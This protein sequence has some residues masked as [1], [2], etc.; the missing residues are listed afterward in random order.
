MADLFTFTIKAPQDHR[1]DALRTVRAGLIARGV[2]QPNVTPG[3]DYYVLFEAVGNELSVCEA[4]GAIKADSQLPDTA[5]DE[6]LGR[7]AAIYGLAKRAAA[8]SVGVVVLDS[9]ASSTITTGTELVDASGFRYEVT[10]GGLYADGAYVPIAAI[11]TGKATNLAVGE[12]LKWVSAPPFSSATAL[13]GPGG[14]INGT[15]AE[16][17]ETL[18]SRLL[19]RLQTPPKSGNWQHVVEIAEESTGHVQKA[20][21]YPAIQ[22]PASLHVAVTAEPTATNKNRNVDSTILSSLVS[23]Y[24]IGQYPEHAGITVTTVANV[25]C[26][27]AFAIAIPDS[28]SASPAGEGGGWLDGTPWPSIN[29][30]STFRCTVTAVSS[31][32]VFTVDAT[33]SPSVGV[34][35][36]S[37]LSPSDW[38]IYTGTVTAVSGT[39]GAYQI[40]LDKP[41]TGIATGSYI[42]P[43]CEKQQTYIDAI[44]AY[45]ALMGPGEKSSNASALIRG[46]RKPLP[47]H[48]WPHSVNQLFLKAL[49][50]AGDEVAHAMFMHRTDGTT[51]ITNA[52]APS[53][54]LTP[55][56]PG[57]VTN[58]PNIYVPR[59]LGLYRIP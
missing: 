17:D 33:T 26:D 28:P 57:T 5:E 16:T 14:L 21:C 37:W 59:N 56:V 58:P 8:G 31:T 46:A 20:F 34:A 36:I 45:F 43:Q 53:L 23:P 12:A 13:V 50:D 39:S 2:S 1:D 32:T 48:A 19:A 7:L 38:T 35:R 18:R 51:T 4:N 11:D 25:N 10:T 44:L 27:V 55:Q 42:W 52:S 54:Q 29:G 3:S 47:S 15:D 41:F 6:D 40:T 9:S 22:G 49:T 30:T 24:V